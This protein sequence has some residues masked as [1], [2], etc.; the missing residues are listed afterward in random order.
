MY[1]LHKSSEDMH[2][3]PFLNFPN[4]RLLWHGS[5]T[6]SLPRILEQSLKVPSPEV[7]SARYL[8]GK[9]IYFHDISSKAANACRPS[10]ENPTVILL[11]CEVALGNMQKA[12]EAK[13]FKR[14]P[15]GYHSVK[16]VGKLC[17]DPSYCTTCEELSSKNA[18]I[19]TGKIRENEELGNLSTELQYNEYVIYDYS[20]VRLRYLIKCHADF[21]DDI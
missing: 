21:S 20:Q 11:L 2:F 14:P 13:A 1:S 9:G 16:G 15:M 17:P 10:K 18:K 4:K 12:Y 6:V 7:P 3:F 8:F 5:R 19:D